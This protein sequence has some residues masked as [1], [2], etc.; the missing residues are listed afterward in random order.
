MA[1]AMR[2]LWGCRH[3][4]TTMPITLREPGGTVNRVSSTYMVCLECG[5][6]IPYS[7]LL[8][9]PVREPFRPLRWAR[10]LVAGIG[11]QTGA[12]SPAAVKKST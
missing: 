10:S 5:E 6:E 9:R 12:G 2:L 1:R 7:W 4:R 8:M 11:F 3:S